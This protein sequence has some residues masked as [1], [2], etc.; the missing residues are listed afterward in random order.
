[1]R[2]QLLTR[3]LDRVGVDQ[4]KGEDRRH[5][6]VIDPGMHRAALD[7]DIARLHVDGLAVVELEV[8]FTRQ[9]DRVIDRLGAV[10]KARRAGCEGGD[11]DHCALA[12]AD[13]V[14]TLDE[15]GALRVARRPFGIVDRHRI[16]RP[17]L[18]PRDAR[19]RRAFGGVKGLVG[20][21]DRATPGVMPGDDAA[22]I[23]S[24]LILPCYHHGET[25]KII[26]PQG[27]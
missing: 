8:A 19:P 25:A 4:H 1:V 3:H 16:G 7:A 14:V 2:R 17:N 9:E 12:A 21:D 27:Q 18:D 20:G 11:A 5:A 24:H 13:I 23:Q 26:S 6:A 22:H 10:H 15:T